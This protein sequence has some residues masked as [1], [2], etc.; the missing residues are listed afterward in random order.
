[1]RVSY[2]LIYLELGLSFHLMK[3]PYL[4]YNHLVTHSWMKMLWE[5]LLLFDVHTEF[6]DTPSYF[7]QDGDQ[8]LMKILSRAGYCGEALRRLNKV[9]VSQQV[10]FL[11]DVLTASGGKVDP[12][13]LSR[14]PQ[15]ET[16]SSMRWPVEHPTDSDMQLWKN[17][18]TS[19]CPSRN[20][21]PTLGK[22]INISHKLRRWYWSAMDSTLHHVRSD[23]ATEDVYIAGRKPNR[24][25][26]SHNQRRQNHD[27]QCSVQPTIDRSQWQ[28]LSTA[29][30]APRPQEP[31]SFLEV[32]ESWGNTW[33]WDDLTV[34]GS[35][36]WIEHT[37]KE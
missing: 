3:E 2:H 13:V 31:S 11:S 7:L 10:L 17:A 36:Q 8:F 5:K 22:N 19:I 35:V 14:R 34:N 20:S 25:Q 28:L 23:G 18:I 29:V 15:H 32:L 24:F 4:K 27:V 12:K 1:M 6:A 37:I 9:R 33:L 21:T 30:L 16:W 26:S